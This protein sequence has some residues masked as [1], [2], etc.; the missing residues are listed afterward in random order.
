MPNHIN[1]ASITPTL[2]RLLSMVFSNL[3]DY[4]M[5]CRAS[6]RLRKKVKFH[7]I[8]AANSQKNRLNFRGNLRGKLCGNQLVKKRLI[9]WLLSG[10]I[11]LEVDRFCADRT[12]V[13]NVFLTESIISSFSNNTLQK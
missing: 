4:A 3:V 13:F 1:K 7:G 11:S 10:N 8:L 6:D 5:L 2:Y 9:L 12:R